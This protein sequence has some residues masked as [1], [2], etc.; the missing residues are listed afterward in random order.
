MSFLRKYGNSIWCLVLI[1]AFVLLYPISS[2]ADHRHSL[3]INS[4]RSNSLQCGLENILQ[5]ADILKSANTGKIAIA[6]AD[7]SS[8]KSPKFAG[9]NSKQM[10]YSASLPKIAILLGALKK[11]EEG[12]LDWDD[13]V[14]AMAEAMIQHSANVEATQLYYKV[15]PDYISDLLKSE[16]LYAPELG[17]G[18]W[19]GKEYGSGAAWER[20][21]E[22]TLS[23]AASP[24]QIARYYYLLETKK[25]LSSSW[26]RKA[27]EILGSTGLKHKFIAGLNECCEGAK[28]YRKS[29][30]WG[31]YHADSAMIDHNGKL[32][33]VAALIND[34]NGGELLKSLIV[35]IDSLVSSYEDDEISCTPSFE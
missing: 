16:E 14:Q 33:I 12:K 9:I 8:K 5:K 30:S 13:E 2:I 3:E 18:L 26:T 25:L 21:E 24:L 28:V 23:H 15:G 4:D 34:S 27:K 35:D 6:L 7:I 19:V 22:C 11:A 29:G 31:T 20:E 32:Y 17:G 10:L 1:L